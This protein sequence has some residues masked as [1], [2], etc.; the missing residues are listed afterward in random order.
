MSILKYLKLN[1][2]GLPDPRGDLSSSISPKAIA[3]TNREVEVEQ[4]KAKKH[5]QYFWY[6]ELSVTIVVFY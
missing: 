1:K 3:L 4:K 6:S 5:G 2:G